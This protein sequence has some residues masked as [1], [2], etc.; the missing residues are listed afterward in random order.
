MMFQRPALNRPMPVSFYAGQASC[1]WQI[2]S[3][4]RT[5]V[6]YLDENIS[7][8]SV[9]VG[10]CPQRVSFPWRPRLAPMFQQRPIADTHYGGLVCPLL[11]ELPRIVQILLETLPIISPQT[12]P[13]HQEVRGKQDI[14]EI[15]LQNTDR[16]QRSPE[17]PNIAW[18]G[19]TRPRKS[20]RSK[21][22]TARL[23][24]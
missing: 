22:N 11:G 2:V 13:D 23:I 16:M 5:L 4:N 20:L 18:I 15:E 6:T 12:R 14:D 10:K 3:R 9:R 8:I 7:Q 1:L 24:G 17:M 21:R 19:R